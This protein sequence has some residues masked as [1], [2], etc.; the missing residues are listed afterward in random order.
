[1][2]FE[3][4]AHYDDDKFDEDRE[5]LLKKMPEEGI[6]CI[7]N[8]GASLSSTKTS[9]ELAEKFDH[10]Y[11]AVGVHPNETGELNEENFVW[12]KSVAKNPK[13]VAIGEIGLDYY[14]KEPEPDV[15]K[16]WFERQ[17]ELAREEKLPMIIHSRDAAKDTMDMIKAC[18]GGSIGGVIHC[19]SYSVEMAKEYLD[20]GFYLGIGG[21]VTFNNAKKLKEVVEYMP[22]DRI[23]LETDCP[24]LA[25]VPNRGK[26]NS[27]LNLKYVVAEIS[28]LKN[29]SEEEIKK[30]TY[31]NAKKLYRMK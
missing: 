16:I 9:L 31:E 28:K 21:V 6:G 18:D 22:L 20:M 10:V 30:V 5:G 19:Y 2:I 11:A 15:Q 12:L 7:V 26:R 24:Y 17:M 23:V 3:T 25:P 4:H 1:M 29:I 14:W 8:V 13:V 27:S